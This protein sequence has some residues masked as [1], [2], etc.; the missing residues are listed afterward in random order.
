MRDDWDPVEVVVSDAHRCNTVDEAESGRTL[1]RSSVVTLSG[2][3]IGCDR[4]IVFDQLGFSLRGRYRY[5]IV[6]GFVPDLR[7]RGMRTRIHIFPGQ[8]WLLHTLRA[9]GRP[10]R[11]T[12]N[13]D[14]VV[15]QVGEANI[16]IVEAIHN[17]NR[18]ENQ[19]DPRERLNTALA[20]HGKRLG[21]TDEQRQLVPSERDRLLLF[22]LDSLR[23]S[24][25]G[26]LQ[27]LSGIAPISRPPDV[28]VF[29][30]HWHLF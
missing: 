1:A 4:L 26:Q 20:P 30:P 16:M 9:R 22:I 6:C 5:K 23:V 12:L 13:L 8:H 3:C 28:Q 24:R 15:V 17:R 10:N 25:Y 11:L 19:R 14:T 27:S 7:L 21:L 2:S 18:A 29:G